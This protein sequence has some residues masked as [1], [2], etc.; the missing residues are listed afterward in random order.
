MPGQEGLLEEARAPQS[1]ERGPSEGRGLA[2]AWLGDMAGRWWRRGGGHRAS[3][4]G[5]GSAGRGL[6]QETRLIPTGTHVE[7]TR[8]EAKVIG[9][10]SNALLTTTTIQTL[11]SCGRA[12]LSASLILSAL[13]CPTVLCTRD[14]HHPRLQMRKR[15]QGEGKQLAEV[16]QRVSC[17]LRPEHRRSASG[18]VLSGAPLGCPVHLHGEPHTSG[19]TL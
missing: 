1:A 9:V 3:F 17:G 5:C 4:S 11:A 18:T 10:S 13:I 8:P 16:T 19:V 2:P 12:L 15:R 6:A 7:P 14:C